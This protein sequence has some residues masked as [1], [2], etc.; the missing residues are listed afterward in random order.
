MLVG[1]I[2]SLALKGRPKMDFRSRLTNCGW[3]LS[4]TGNA[5]DGSPIEVYH[6]PGKENSV[7]KLYKTSKPFVLYSNYTDV[8]VHRMATTPE[9]ID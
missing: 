8:N 6:H 3:E 5:I 7:A 2:P 1:S 9:E 4:F